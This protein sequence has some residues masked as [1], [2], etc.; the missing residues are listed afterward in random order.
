MRINITIS[1][2]R[3]DDVEQLRNNMQAVIRALLSFQNEPRLLAT[4]CSEQGSVNFMNDPDS[5]KSKRGA[6]ASSATSS[7]PVSDDAL[8]NVVEPLRTPTNDLLFCIKDGLQRCDA[9]LMDISGY[10]KYLGPD[11]ETPSDVGPIQIHTKHAI[12]AFDIAESNIL[13][14][15][16]TPVSSIYDPDVIHLLVF[17]RRV[18][19]TIMTVTTLMDQVTAM[20]RVPDWPRVYLPSY[21]IWKAIHRTNAQ[22]RHDRGGVTAG[23]YQKTFVEIARLL[24]KIKSLDYKPM[25]RFENETSKEESQTELNRPTMDSSTDIAPT[26]KKRK[27]RYKIWRGLYRLQGF[28]SRYAFKVCLVTS[29]LSIP[30]YLPQSNGW[31]DQ[32]EV[33][34]VVVVSW[35]VMHPRVGGNV[36]DLVTR[37]GVAILGAVWSGIGSAAGNGN[38]YVMG[39]FAALYMIPMLYRYTISSHPV[40]AHS[41]RLLPFY[42]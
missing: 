19:E 3:P 18:R 28:E 4:D 8:H 2:F 21:P 14:S 20:Q 9:A 15:D 24:D 17:S 13:H 11:A 31:W 36:Q 1:R 22:V 41:P 34:W 27:L 35:A 32:Y 26:S 42:L 7:P 12:A 39:V 10:R 29:L 16:N 40:S 25:S 5:D 23:Y 37:S 33:W 30:S 38:P 6:T